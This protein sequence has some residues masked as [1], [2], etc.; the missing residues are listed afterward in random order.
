MFFSALENKKWD[1]DQCKYKKLISDKLR[2]KQTIY[3]K[4]K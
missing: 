4:V 2:L 1:L 3:K